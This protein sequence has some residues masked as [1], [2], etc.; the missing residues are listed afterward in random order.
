MTDLTPQPSPPDQAP[1]PEVPPEVP[2]KA[3]LTVGALVSYVAV[4]DAGNEHTEVALVTSVFT[5]DDVDHARVAHLS[6]P[7]ALPVDALTSI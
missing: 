1:T 6:A 5:A 4:D 7:L 3:P 2:A